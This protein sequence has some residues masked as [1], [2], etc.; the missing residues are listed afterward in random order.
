MGGS[1]PGR[2]IERRKQEFNGNCKLFGNSVE[3]PQIN[4]ET[5]LIQS[6]I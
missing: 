5:R 4:P 2:T 3:K 6:F 1:S